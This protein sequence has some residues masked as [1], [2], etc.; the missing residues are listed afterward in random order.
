VSAVRAKWLTAILL[1]AS[2]GVIALC[3]PKLSAGHRRLRE[4]SDVYV[5]PPPA[6]VV[7]LALGY[8]A[9]L[10][11]YLWAHVLVSQGLHTFEKRRFEHLTLYLDTINALDPQFRDPYLMAD[12]LITFQANETPLEEVRKAREIMERG[13]AARPLDAELWLVLGQFVAYIAPGSY[14]T[15]K[16][17]IDRWRREGAQILARAAELGSA[18]ANISWQALGGAGILHRAGERDAAIRFLQRTL[19][20]TD[21]EELKDELRRRLRV[22]LGEQQANEYQRREAAMKE[23]WFRGDVRF[24]RKRE[25]V[26]LLGPDHDDAYCAGG[27]HA[28]DLR[29]ARTWR[30]WS[31]RFERSARGAEQSP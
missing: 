22:L 15:D 1:L 26:L 29:C 31:E 21:D 3:L 5:L 20:V 16:Q 2:V 9:A 25:T 10:A 7:R 23:Q 12:A 11:D 18:D 28:D 13:V 8:R 24:V 4:T 6:D 17:E 30:E 19:A 14:L 27:A